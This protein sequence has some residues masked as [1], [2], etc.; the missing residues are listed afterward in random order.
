MIID[1]F[2]FKTASGA[3]RLNMRREGLNDNCCLGRFPCLPPCWAPCTPCASIR[4]PMYPST[5]QVER[6]SCHDSLLPLVGRALDFKSN[7]SNHFQLY[8]T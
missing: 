4:G 5:H 7:D 8:L 2:L 3:L 1:I 6:P